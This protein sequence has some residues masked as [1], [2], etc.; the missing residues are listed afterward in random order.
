MTSK[1]FDGDDFIAKGTK[2]VPE[3]KAFQRILFLLF[4][5]RD[6][7]LSTQNRQPDVRGLWDDPVVKSLHCHENFYFRPI[8]PPSSKAS[9]K[10]EYLHRQNFFD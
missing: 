7:V 9:R 1:T 10:Q 4:P 2:N 3:S 8:L 6:L 5:F